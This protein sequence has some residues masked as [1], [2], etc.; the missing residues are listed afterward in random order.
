MTRT[1]SNMKKAYAMAGKPTYAELEQRIRELELARSKHCQESLQTFQAATPLQLVK[2]SPGEQ[3]GDVSSSPPGSAPGDQERF[4]S[5]LK[6]TEEALQHERELLSIILD[7]NP[8]GIAVIDRAGNWQYVNPTFTEITGYTLQ[9]VPTG[10]AWIR[11]AY[12][13]PDYRKN[14]LKVWKIDRL[15]SGRG[16]LTESRVTCK[17][18]RTKDIEFITTYLRDRSVLAMTDITQRKIAEKSLH[19]AK[20]I[21]DNVSDI[22]YISD[23][24]GNITY[25]NPAAGRISGLPME[26]IIGQPILPLVLEKDRKNLISAFQR[27]LTGQNL[28][29][30]LTLTSGRTCHLSSLPLKDDRGKI[31]G[32]FGIARDISE[33]LQTE[34]AL[35]ESEARLRKA[36]SV[37]RIGSWELDLASGQVWGSDQAFRIY[38]IERTSPDL[39]LDRIEACISDADRVK[40]ALADLVRDNK[41]YDIEFEVRQAQGGQSVVINSVAELVYENGVPVKVLGVIRDI[42]AEKRTRAE[43]EKLRHQ[44]HL[45]QRLESVGSLAGGVAHDLNNLLTPILGYG[46]MLALDF[47]ADNTRKASVEQIIEAAVRARDLVHQLLAFSRRQV[48][49]FAPLD[50]NGVLQRFEPLLRRTIREDIAIRIIAGDGVPVIR[51]DIGQLEQV[52]MNLTVNAQDAMP[53]GGLLTIETTPV[54]LDEAYTAAR[55]GVL[56]GKYVLLAVSDTGLGLDEDVKER[57]FEPFF[58]TKGK[59]GTGLGLSTVYGIVKQHRGNIWVYSERGLG[60]TF[61]L[62]LPVSTEVGKAQSDPDGRRSELHGSETILL[63]EDNPQVLAVA[64]ILLEEMG[65]R[66]H[67]AESGEKALAFMAAY[68]EP[69]HLLL[70]DVVMPRMNGKELFDQLAARHPAIKVLFMSGYTNS[71]I[72]HH[73]VLDEGVQFIQKPF[74]MRALGDKVREVLDT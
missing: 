46:E 28:E 72:A 3:A 54:T 49:E 10:R 37:A 35:A 64:Q 69:V 21:L 18:G 36:Q 32:T 22:A 27:T 63:V 31:V 30:T 52:I 24:E 59:G 74:S 7:N 17:N 60:T 57:I 23:T 53:D 66:V 2:N 65:Y 4:I 39:P 56:P 73:G 40:Q 16:Q 51:G 55:P 67:S 29:I 12:P 45:S 44:L 14:V 6:K 8:H 1:D 19:E 33:R 61:K 68:D 71:I 70:T 50:L 43:Q 20:L 15:R 42:T 47:A 9:D 38:G 25:V 13:D 41:P 34:K 5:Q 58:S 48:L 11:K 62:Y 26:D